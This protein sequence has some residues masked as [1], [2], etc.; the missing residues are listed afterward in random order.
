M[1][2]DGTALVRFDTLRQD[3]SGYADTGQPWVAVVRY[4]FVD[5]PMQLDDRLINPL[6]F[7]VVSYRRDAE[8]PPPAPVTPA[9]VAPGAETWGAAPPSGPQPAPGSVQLNGG[10]VERRAVP[11]DNV[12]LGSPLVGG[13]DQ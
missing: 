3:R 8:G 6:G 4:R 10:T 11:I 1:L 13:R 12:P 5:A 2:S 7:Q 9:A